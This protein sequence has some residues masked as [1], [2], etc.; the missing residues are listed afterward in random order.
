MTKVLVLYGSPRKNGNTSTLGKK[1]LQGL[2]DSGIEE[3]QEF[4]LNDLTI[5]PCQGCF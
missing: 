3:V 1:F 2:T 4:W 5:K